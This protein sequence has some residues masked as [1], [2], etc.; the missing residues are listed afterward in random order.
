MVVAKKNKHP[1]VL[2]WSNPIFLAGNSIQ[3][4]SSMISP[5]CNCLLGIRH[6]HRLGSIRCR[7]QTQLAIALDLVASVVPVIP[8]KIGK[9][10]KSFTSNGI[11][12]VVPPR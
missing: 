5:G 4:I 3:K 2:T 1:T 11:Y 10:V 8:K 6:K 12:K 9:H 7:T